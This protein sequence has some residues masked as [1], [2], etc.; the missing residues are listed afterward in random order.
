M[1]TTDYNGQAVEQFKVKKFSCL[2]GQTNLLLFEVKNQ[3][4][5]MKKKKKLNKKFGADKRES[6]FPD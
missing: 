4:D 5:E 3:A 2:P 6:K 1:V